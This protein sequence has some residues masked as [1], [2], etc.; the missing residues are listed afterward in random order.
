MPASLLVSGFEPVADVVIN[1]RD[2]SE[3][4]ADFK[5]PACGTWAITRNGEALTDAHSDV[6]GTPRSLIQRT[7][8]PAEP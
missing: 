3:R 6:Y 1:H 5:N 7:S 8:V 4:W 2:G